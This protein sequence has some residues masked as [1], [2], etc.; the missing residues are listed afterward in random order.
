MRCKMFHSYQVPDVSFVH[1]SRLIAQL[2][3]GLQYLEFRRQPMIVD[4]ASGN[5][6]NEVITVSLV[7]TIRY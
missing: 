5:E 1:S 3:E 7:T 4:S 6:D 2:A